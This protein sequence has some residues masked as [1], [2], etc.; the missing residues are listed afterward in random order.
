MDCQLRL[1]PIMIVQ[2]RAA[3]SVVSVIVS[4]SVFVFEFVFVFVCVRELADESEMR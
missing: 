1:R 3:G 4:V 2:L